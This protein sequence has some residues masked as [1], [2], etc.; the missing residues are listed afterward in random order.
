MYLFLFLI[1][2]WSYAV[3][4]LTG[5]SVQVYLYVGFNCLGFWFVCLYKG[6]DC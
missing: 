5:S 4:V 1:Y 6:F 2:V 3:S